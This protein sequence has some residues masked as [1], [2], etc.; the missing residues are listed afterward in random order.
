M[1]ELLVPHRPERL[2]NG[3]LAAIVHQP[4][5]QVVAPHRFVLDG[6]GDLHQRG[7]VHHVDARVFAQE[8]TAA[9]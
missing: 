6:P 3:G 5:E 8:R 1:A 7:H 2:G 9:R 4:G